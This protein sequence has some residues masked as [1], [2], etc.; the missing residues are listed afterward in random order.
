MA[1]RRLFRTAVVS[2]DVLL[3]GVPL[4][5][6]SEVSEVS[7][8]SPSARRVCLQLWNSDPS[9]PPR[10]RG[11]RPGAP[12][13]GASGPGGRRRLL[14]KASGSLA[15]IPKPGTGPGALRKQVGRRGRRRRR[16]SESL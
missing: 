2:A 9:A 4:V 7:P 13:R 8:R 1:L 10:L 5:Y 14:N 3:R 15:R 12:D 11:A 16:T 6:F